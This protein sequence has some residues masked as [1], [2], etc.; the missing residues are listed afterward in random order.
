L[1]NLAVATSHGSEDIRT[2]GSHLFWDPYQHQWIASNKLSNGEHLLTA[3]G[4][5]AIADGGT[6]PKQHDCWMWDLTVPGN[7]DHDF[8]VLA[9]GASVRTYHGLAGATPILVHNTGPDCGVP[10]GGKNGDALGGEDFHG[11]D[12]SLD[13]GR[14]PQPPRH[15][16]GRVGSA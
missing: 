15:A 14:G 8:Y 7:N 10:V 3:N 6:I 16:S 4:T 13:D 5:V 2:T 11:S 9:V 1:D 12:Y